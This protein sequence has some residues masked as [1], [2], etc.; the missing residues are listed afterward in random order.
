M[1]CVLVRDVKKVPVRESELR[2]G[3]IDEPE[4]RL[5]MILYKYV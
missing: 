4:K 1:I 3:E 2:R 5:T